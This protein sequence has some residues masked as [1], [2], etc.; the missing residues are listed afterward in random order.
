[1]AKTIRNLT[2]VLVLMF[3]VLLTSA[4]RAAAE[5]PLPS[6]VKNLR[7]QWLSV[8]NYPPNGGGSFV[9]QVSQSG[10]ALQVDVDGYETDE[11]GP[12]GAGIVSDAK[13]LILMD[14]GFKRSGFGLVFA[15]KLLGGSLIVGSCQR[16]D[17]QI[18][19][20]LALKLGGG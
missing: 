9:M 20:W 4:H 15:G 19:T 18:G 5:S 10:T 6:A 16:P 14:E 8:V 1:M 17:G 2:H 12:V 11:H 3:A 7:G 13:V